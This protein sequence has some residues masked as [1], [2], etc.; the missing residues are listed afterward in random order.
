MD[1]FFALYEYSL[2]AFLAYDSKAAAAVA[3][4]ATSIATITMK[5]FFV[6][7]LIAC[8]GFYGVTAAPL[9]QRDQA[10]RRAADKAEHLESSHRELD[11]K[12]NKGSKSNK[13][14]KPTR[15]TKPI[16]QNLKRDMVNI[17][18][19]KGEKPKHNPER[20]EIAELKVQLSK[21]AD[22]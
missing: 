19:D 13:I 22:D 9:G 21:A 11:S 6:S 10:L 3:A 8:L 16:K 20:A 1:V 7:C 5:A 18:K 15:A 12:K 2:I 14:E 17:K 4:T